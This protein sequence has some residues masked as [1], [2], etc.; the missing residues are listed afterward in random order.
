M[1]RWQRALRAAL[2]VLTVVG[3]SSSGT[4]S[5]RT[6]P[7]V[8]KAPPSVWCAGRRKRLTATGWGMRFS[9]RAS[10]HRQAWGDQ[11]HLRLCA[12]S[13]DDE[14]HQLELRARQVYEV[15]RLEG[16]HP[17]AQEEIGTIGSCLGDCKNVTPE[18]PYCV[19]L[20]FP[21]PVEQAIDPADE[22]RPGRSIAMQVSARLTRDRGPR[23]MIDLVTMFFVAPKHRRP[24]LCLAPAIASNF[25]VHAVERQLPP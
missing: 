12:Q 8:G 18:F 1:R 16:E 20:R 5:T 15:R 4:A 7:S 3:G 19:T 22:I 23:V 2:V 6:L 25:V 14:S 17:I 10:L 13:T 24:E 9:M 21:E 11:I